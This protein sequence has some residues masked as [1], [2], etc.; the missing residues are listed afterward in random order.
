MKK[1][2]LVA[3]ALTFSAPVLAHA[4]NN[5]QTE[6]NHQNGDEHRD[7]EGDRQRGDNDSNERHG[8]RSRDGEGRH[9]N[10]KHED[11]QRGEHGNRDNNNDSNN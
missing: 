9:H 2:L 4:E 5:D 7:H 3:A 10:G 11:R 8:D 1:L 6:M